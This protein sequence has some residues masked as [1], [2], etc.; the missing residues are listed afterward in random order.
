MSV[1]LVTVSL[2]HETLSSITHLYLGTTKGLGKDIWTLQPAQ[3]DSILRVSLPQLSPVRTFRTNSP[4]QNLW[5]SIFAYTAVLAGVQ[6]SVIMFYMRIFGDAHPR[7]RM[8]CMVIIGACL[9]T[10]VAAW[11]GS[12]F[13]CSSIPL[14][15]HLWDGEHAGNCRTA[16]AQIYATAGINIFLDLVILA[17]PIPKL[18]DLN[19][20]M[21]RKVGLGATFLVGLVT[22]CAS[23][24]RLRY[25]ITWGDTMNPTWDYND[26]AIASTYECHLSIIC[27]CM[28]SMAGLWKRFCRRRKVS[29]LHS[30]RTRSTHHQ[31]STS[32]EIL[33]QKP[34]PVHGRPRTKSSVRVTV[35]LAEFLAIEEGSNATELELTQRGIDHANE[36]IARIKALV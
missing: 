13:F 23:I 27:A 33:F 19:V 31:A 32:K 9:S 20:S 28:P 30:Q 26:T 34:E 35:S 3:I 22:T 15:W 36:E 11:I 12:L 5:I 7:F 6:V 18:H 4:P 10:G 8:L 24:V 2:T 21:A 16:H 17:L 14:F 29:E 25:L 1:C